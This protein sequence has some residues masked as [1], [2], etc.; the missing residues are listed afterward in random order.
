MSRYMLLLYASDPTPQENTNRW[1]ELPAW[2]EVSESM[3]E[4]SMGRE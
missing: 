4:W 2:E 1:A 3:R